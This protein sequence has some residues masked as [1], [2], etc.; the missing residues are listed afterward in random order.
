M[1]IT[2]EQLERLISTKLT[3]ALA[4]ATSGGIFNISNDA[5][6]DP[7]NVSGN[8][9]QN[10]GKEVAKLKYRLRTTLSSK[11][12]KASRLIDHGGGGGRTTI[13]RK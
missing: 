12:L 9:A 7:V 5:D 10:I 1:P 13:I 2:P 4:S 6:Q 3:A 11:P 8:T